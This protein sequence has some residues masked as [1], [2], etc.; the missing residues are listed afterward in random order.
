MRPSQHVAEAILAL[1]ADRVRRVAIDGVDGAGKT[2]FADAL[3]VELNVRGAKVIRVSADGFLN[4]PRT[5]HRRGRDSPE[6]F[7]RDSYDYGRM[8]RLLLD[9]L[10]P[11]GNREYIRE[12]YDVRR[13]RE[14]RRLPELAADDAILVLDGIFVHRDE[15]VRYWDYSVWLEVPFEV[16]VPRAAKRGVGIKEE[17]PYALKNLRYVEGQRLYMAECRPRT[18][19]SVVIDNADLANPVLLD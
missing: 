12:V 19:A 11:G 1:P 2:H 4:P 18:R 7:Y 8:V 9:P 3:G 16:S 6:G 14:V 17:D 5:R 13:E 10:S 15:L